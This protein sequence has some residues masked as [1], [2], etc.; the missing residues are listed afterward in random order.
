MD[1]RIH[2]VETSGMV[3]GPGIRYVIFTQGCL[4]RCQYCHNPDTWDRDKGNIM[5]VEN[6][7]NDIKRYLPYMKRSNGGVTVSGGEPLLQIDFLI[8]L[9]KELKALGIH[10]TI[11]SSGGCYSNNSLFQEKLKELFKYID[12]FLV[13]IKHMDEKK[14]KVLTGV[15]NKH[16]LQFAKQLSDERVP[17]W[18][19]HVLVPGHSDDEQDLQKLSDFIQT[20]SNV[21][22]VEILPYH[23]MGVYKWQELGFDYPLEGV[24]PPSEEQVTNAKTILGIL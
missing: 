24:S 11:D 12:L 14:H 21:E 22:K 4:L 16:I 2:S 23:K 6:L 3:D 8:A 19:R 15:S 17:I 9:F 1:G 10:T 13:D 7:V 5:S 18:V 20:L